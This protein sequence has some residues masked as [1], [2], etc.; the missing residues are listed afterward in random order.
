[1]TE[2][3]LARVNQYKFDSNFNNGASSNSA[4]A[5]L[6]QTSQNSSIW[7]EA[8]QLENK[9]KARIQVAASIDPMSTTTVMNDFMNEALD[10]LFNSL[11][12]PSRYSSS[13]TGVSSYNEDNKVNNAGTNQ[14]AETPK[15]NEPVTNSVSN[16]EPAAPVEEPKQEVVKN[17]DKKSL[18]AQKES[19]KQAALIH[20]DESIEKVIVDKNISFDD[21]IEIFAE[22]LQEIIKNTKVV[23]YRPKELSE[24]HFL[25]YLTKNLASGALSAKD[26]VKAIEKIN[27]VQKKNASS[28]ATGYADYSNDINQ[29][30]VI[31]LY[32]QAQKEGILAKACGAIYEVSG[33]NP[34]AKS[35]TKP[36]QQ[37][38][39]GKK[40]TDG[41]VDM[42]EGFDKN[43]TDKLGTDA[44]KY[45]ISKEREAEIKKD[46]SSFI[47]VS[48]KGSADYKKSKINGLLDYLFG[49]KS[50]YND[51]E[52]VYFI[53]LFAAGAKNIN[54][55]SN[56]KKY[57]GMSDMEYFIKEVFRDQ[58][59]FDQ[60]LYLDKILKA[61]AYNSTLLK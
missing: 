61:Y 48:N 24:T 40:E 32:K 14:G 59:W 33:T 58:W 18:E 47:E 53:K 41:L 8:Q 15:S 1:M 2:S 12:K 11:N 50:K 35:T 37:G 26:V 5:A 57:E 43:I 52:R 21:K 42:F 13:T 46:V 25:Q 6:N 10:L 38:V 44:P 22:Y 36:L 20:D 3:F 45:N 4:F 49:E 17:M 30:F 55:R 54:A 29:E 34:G 31:K 51:Y 7:Q 23:G 60:E 39:S 56:P 27:E 9:Y 19:A 16:E 28:S